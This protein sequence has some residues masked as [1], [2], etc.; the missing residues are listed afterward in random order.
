M[1]C[2]TEPIAETPEPS[3]EGT[4]PPVVTAAESTDSD[5]GLSVGGVA[6]IVVGALA[7]LL[8]GAGYALHLNGDIS[9]CH[10]VHVH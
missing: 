5:D 2:F 10:R 9:C 6:G 1:W 3:N 4:I 7:I 8:G